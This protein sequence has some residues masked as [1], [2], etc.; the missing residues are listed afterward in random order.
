MR[1]RLGRALERRG[2]Q[3]A[4]AESVAEAQEKIAEHA[5]AYAVIDMKLGDGSGLAVV[6]SLRAARPDTRIVMLTGYGNIASAVAGVKAGAVDYLLQPAGRGQVH[7]E[8]KRRGLRRVHGDK[9]KKMR[10]TKQMGRMECRHRERKREAGGKRRMKEEE[11]EEGRGKGGKKER[12]GEKGGP[13]PGLQGGLLCS[14]LLCNRRHEPQ[15]DA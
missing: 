7:A 9:K 2:F 1:N 6:T 15:H 5:P 4:L 12:K 10:A 8:K 3:I 13:L 11:K 14:G